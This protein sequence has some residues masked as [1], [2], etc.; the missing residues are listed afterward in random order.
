MT[1]KVAGIGSSGFWL[2]VLLGFFGLVHGSAQTGGCTLARQLYTCDRAQFQPI[3]AAAFTVQVEASP[4]DRVAA[5]K[6]RDLAVALGKTVAPLDSQADLLFSLV[7]LPTDGVLI[8]PAG[9]ELAV[10]RIYGPPVN[11]ARGNLVWAETYFG[12][13][14]RSWPTVVQALIQ[15]FRAGIKR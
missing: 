9:T 6:L 13:A 11:G 10:L 15:Q 2:A 4:R 5:A 8:G 3:L 1:T 14:D 12:Q 7:P